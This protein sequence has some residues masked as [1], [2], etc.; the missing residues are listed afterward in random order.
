MSYVEEK[1]F[2]KAN[3]KRIY[4]AWED[5]YLKKGAYATQ[6]HHKGIKFRVDDKVKN[7]SMTI[8]W[9]SFFVKL[10]F[11]YKVKDF[12]KGSEVYCRVKFGGFFG[13]IIKLFASS[14]IRKYLQISLKKFKN[15]LELYK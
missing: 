10:V 6:Q 5:N 4:R 1:I 13:F 14:K 12:K 3:K 11:Q 15:D 2:I 7:E 9:H 8:T